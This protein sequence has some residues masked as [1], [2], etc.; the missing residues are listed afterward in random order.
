MNKDDIKEDI[1]GMMEVEPSTTSGGH[2]RPKRLSATATR[3][4]TDGV[5]AAPGRFDSNH[6]GIWVRV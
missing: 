6:N 2:A 5:D 3:P 1:Q 4:N